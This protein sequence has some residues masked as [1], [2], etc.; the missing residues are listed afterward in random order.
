MCLR[1]I[2]LLPRAKN[3]ALGRLYICRYRPQAQ[4]HIDRIDT[5]RGSEGKLADPMLFRM[6]SGA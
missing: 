3:G 4:R 2:N 6:A 1:Q 5:E